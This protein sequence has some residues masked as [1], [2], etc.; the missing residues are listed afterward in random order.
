MEQAFFFTGGSS[1]KRQ[2]FYTVTYPG[3]AGRTFTQKRNALKWARKYGGQGWTVYQGRPDA[4]ATVASAHQELVSAAA[5]AVEVFGEDELERY[6][7][8]TRKKGGA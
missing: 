2:D 3:E 4:G 8:E 6:A 7:A 5:E 1:M